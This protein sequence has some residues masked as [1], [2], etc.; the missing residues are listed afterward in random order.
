MTLEEATVI[1]SV[2]IQTSAFAKMKERVA[3]KEY[4]S[5]SDYIRKCIDTYEQTL[6]EK[7]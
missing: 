3:N 5:G 2:N 6:A 1:T 4:K 7:Q